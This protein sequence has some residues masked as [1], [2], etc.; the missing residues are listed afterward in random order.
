MTNGQDS[1][2]HGHEMK[3]RPMVDV[4]K[5]QMLRCKGSGVDLSSIM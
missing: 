1:L 4:V 2:K 5:V 3:S